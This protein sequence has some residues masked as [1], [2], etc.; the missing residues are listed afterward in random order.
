MSFQF[1]TRTAPV[2]AL[3]ASTL[4]AS[5]FLGCAS[6]AP[7]SPV[8]A[9]STAISLE[10]SWVRELTEIWR[11]DLTAYLKRGGEDW[12]TRLSR[13]RDVQTRRGLRPGRICFSTLAAGG[14]PDSADS[15][16]VDGLLLGRQTLGGRH[17]YL[18]IV[19]VVRREGFRPVEIRDLRL[20]AFATSGSDPLWRQ[21]EAD[22]Q[23]LERYKETYRENIPIRFPADDDSYRIEVAGYQVTV[24]ELRSGAEWTLLLTDRS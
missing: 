12:P 4:L 15:W 1:I 13:L 17:W 8:V 6:R 10:E 9:P 20:A 19:G 3:L 21:G 23:S 2:L 16:D 18:F 14:D 5:L 22:P 24:R 11:D 7:H